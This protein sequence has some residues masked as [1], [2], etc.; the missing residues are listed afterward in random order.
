MLEGRCISVHYIGQ[1]RAYQ[2]KTCSLSAP[3]PFVLVLYPV[4]ITLSYV[5]ICL[6]PPAL[7]QSHPSSLCSSQSHLSI[8][9]V[10]QAWAF[11][12]IIC[13]WS[14]PLYWMR[15]HF[16]LENCDSHYLNFIN[17]SILNT[18]F[19]SSDKGQ[20]KVI[21]N[22][23]KALPTFLCEVC[24]PEQGGCSISWHPVHFT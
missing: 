16:H 13:N 6:D 5:V 4:S 12:C 20:K 10:C 23:E 14:W 1:H 3:L 19:V 18:G 17:Y 9:Y 22:V 8:L 15:R 21:Q 7:H 11:A 24:K 2:A